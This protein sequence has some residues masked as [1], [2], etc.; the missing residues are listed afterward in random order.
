MMAKHISQI[1]VFAIIIHCMG[2]SNNT[3]RITDDNVISVNEL[4]AHPDK[5]DRTFVRVNGYVVIK[6]E[7]RN[8]FDSKAGYESPQGICLG[9]AGPSK[10]FEKLY[11][12][13]ATVAG[14]FRRNL[15]GKSDICLYWCS[16]SGIDLKP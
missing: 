3:T 4:V 8:I 10:M 13:T 2:C 11:A 14:I 12:K 1:V 16:D 15:C 9:L 5:Y 6:A 7:G